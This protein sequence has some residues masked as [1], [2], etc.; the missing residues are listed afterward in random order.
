MAQGFGELIKYLQ[1]VYKRRYL[2]VGAALLVTSGFVVYAYRLPRLYQADSTVFIETSA[3]DN[4]FKGMTV[5]SDRD[6]GIRVLKYALLS[7]DILGKVLTEID[8]EPR[9]GNALQEQIAG[10]QKRTDIKVSGKDLFMVSIVDRNPVFAQTFINTLVSKYV[11]ESLIG[12]QKGSVAANQFLDQQLAQ[13]TANLARAEDAITA[14]RKTQGVLPVDDEKVVLQSI[15]DY[16][17]ELENAELTE[18]SLKSKR[19]QLQSQLRMVREA[20]SVGGEQ[21]RDQR[22]AALESELQQLLLTYTEDY[23]GV[24]RIRRDLAEMK[25]RAS[26]RSGVSATVAID[27]PVAREIQQKIYEV[28]AEASALQGRKTTLGNFLAQR[29]Q[30]LQKVPENNNQLTMLIQERDSI[31]KIHEDLMTR[32]SQ[33]GVSEQMGIWAQASTFRVVDPALLP[34]SP[35]SPDMVRMILLAIAAGIGSGLATVLLYDNFD[36]RIKDVGEVRGLGVQI[37][38]VVPA[39]IGTDQVS[40]QKRRDLLVYTF[41]GFYLSGILA[42]LAYEAIR[43]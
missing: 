22:V 6:E 18:N 29:E 35:V 15:T 37:L 19:V 5:T 21:N 36:S 11:E 13:V 14:F 27:D 26:D 3:I 1:V 38:A 16:R 31:K 23:P 4:L 25:R 12:K 24:Q 30:E 20:G 43:G 8:P 10:L 40:Q 2:F 33:S 39:M 9:Q 32:L 34:V 7:R 17:R 42:L 41:S 28:D